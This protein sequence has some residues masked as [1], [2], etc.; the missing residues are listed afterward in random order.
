MST[1]IVFNLTVG[2]LS[3]S[4]RI[5]GLA[6]CALVVAGWTGRPA[7]APAPRSAKY[8][9]QMTG[10]QE[11][12]SNNG[13]ST[14]T[15]T[16][17]IDGTKLQYIVLVHDLSGSPTSAHIHVGAAGVAGPPV[18]TFAVKPD[19]GTDGTI[20]EAPSI[21]PRMRAPAYRATRSRCS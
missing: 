4:D 11:T 13:K 15:A 7:H 9:A 2:V 5:L 3:M 12:P 1:A 21:S 6:A 8:V 17:T 18:Y 14:A 19:S 10:A 20:A 16:F